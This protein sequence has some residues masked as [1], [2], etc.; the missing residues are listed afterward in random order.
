MDSPHAEPWRARLRQLQLEFHAIRS[1]RGGYEGAAI[2]ARVPAATRQ[3]TQL[4]L[5]R[6]YAGGMRCV[7]HS[8]VLVAQPLSSASLQQ[9]LDAAF[10]ARAGGAAEFSEV[11][12]QY[13]KLGWRVGWS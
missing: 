2:L 11:L 3:F 10:W 9:L 13:G 6:L 8:D 5:G 12:E 1:A 4:P 7:A